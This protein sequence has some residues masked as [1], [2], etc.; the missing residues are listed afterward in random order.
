[1]NLPAVLIKQK[2]YYDIRKLRIDLKKIRD[3]K[4][5]L[6]DK[7]TKSLTNLEK[8]N[9]EYTQKCNDLENEI[10]R[11]N[12][13]K[14]EKSKPSEFEDLIEQKPKV[15]PELEKKCKEIYWN[16]SKKTHP[17][18]T[19]DQELINLFSE[20]QIAYQNL[21]LLELQRIQDVVDSPNTANINNIIKNAN[22]EKL[23][24]EH[25]L[26]LKE[27]INERLK[28]RKMIASIQFKI[29][30]LHSSDDDVDNMV[31]NKI[32]LDVM[33]AKIME[34]KQKLESLKQQ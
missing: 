3:K 17:D 14:G 18:I 8:K 31:G 27:I 9:S 26:L 11:T 22:S 23:K 2:Y 21:D 13:K 28:V 34:L 32:F 24:F 7:I 29:H 12:A 4:E 1:M 15:D 6:N 33:L 25:D 10:R 20:A 30:T 16:I 5:E 19:S